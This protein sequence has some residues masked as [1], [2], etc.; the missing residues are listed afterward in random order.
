MK[1]KKIPSSMK[2]ISSTYVPKEKVPEQTEILPYTTAID[3]IQNSFQHRP[4]NLST[5]I[6]SI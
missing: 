1:Q 5:E 3:G 6:N 2:I 4:Y